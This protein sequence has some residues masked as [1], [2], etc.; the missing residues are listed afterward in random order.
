MILHKPG[1]GRRV[2]CPTINLGNLINPLRMAILTNNRVVVETALVLGK[3]EF[4]QPIMLECVKIVISDSCIPPCMLRMA[5]VT[6]P[7]IRQAAVKTGLRGA[8]L[9]NIGVALLA[10][11]G[12]VA[13]PGSMAHRTVRL[14]FGMGSKAG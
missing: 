6:F 8:L 7:C 14:K 5:P 2:A 13:L 9:A 12:R 10:A 4:S 11:F 1:V 3:A